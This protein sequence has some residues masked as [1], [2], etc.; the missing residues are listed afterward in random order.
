MDVKERLHR[1]I[2]AL[3][4]E[5]A[6]EAEHMLRLLHEEDDEYICPHCGTSEHV[7]ND[8]TMQALKESRAG[9]GLTRADDLEELFRKLRA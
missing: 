2:D 5:K 9:I 1:L 7:L 4:E 3:P 6:A 8:E